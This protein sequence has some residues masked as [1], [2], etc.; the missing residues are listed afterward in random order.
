MYKSWLLHQS[1][2]FLP[3]YCDFWAGQADKLVGGGILVFDGGSGSA[4]A[5][6]LIF[7]GA[8]VALVGAT[9]SKNRKVV[10]VGVTTSKSRKAVWKVYITASRNIAGS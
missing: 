7:F 8:R 4:S 10:S 1:C 9:T 3:L 2:F 5:S 6:E